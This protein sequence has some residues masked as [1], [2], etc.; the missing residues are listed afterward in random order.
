MHCC[1][2]TETLNI[3]ITV[4]KGY[5]AF[6]A[7]GLIFGACPETD[8]IH[9]TTFKIEIIWSI[10]CCDNRSGMSTKSL[11]WYLCSRFLHNVLTFPSVS[12]VLIERDISGKLV[13]RFI[14]EVWWSK[15][16]V[17]CQCSMRQNGC[18]ARKMNQ[19][20]IAPKAHFRRKVA[21]PIF[22]H[23]IPWVYI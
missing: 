8:S 4:R 23:K 13:I 22:F 15:K 3:Y 7:K 14:S 12:C 19:L 20:V 5:C 2:R 21:L 1:E 10:K 18:I 11:E 17:F 9:K 16:R 6:G